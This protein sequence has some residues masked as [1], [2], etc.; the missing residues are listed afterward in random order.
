MEVQKILKTRR[1]ADSIYVD[2]YK[3]RKKNDLANGDAKFVCTR[4][5]CAFV[6]YTTTDYKKIT[7][8]KNGHYLDQDPLNIHPPYDEAHIRM[9]CLRTEAKRKAVEDVNSRP[10]KIIKSVLKNE[11][12]DNNINFEEFSHL[13]KS[14]YMVRKKK[15]PVLPKN[16]Q[17]AQTA[18]F[19]IKENTKTQKNEQFCFCDD[20]REIFVFTTTENLKLLCDS[21]EVFGDGTFDFAPKFFTQ[22]YTLHVFKNGYT[23]PLV[24]SFLPKKDEV[25]YNKMWTLIKDLCVNLTNHQL[26]IPVFVVDF[27]QAANCVYIYLRTFRLK[28]F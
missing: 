11:E 21:E 20:N 24:F 26:N 28:N 8:F 19:G 1:G 17:E 6:A 18:L 2:S 25:T 22:L 16:L 4:K 7:D 14:V 3:L 27:E 9:D 5:G 10:S 13:R 15:Y 12:V 23:L